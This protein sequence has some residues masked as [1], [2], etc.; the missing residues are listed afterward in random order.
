[1]GK[2]LLVLALTLFVIGIV[3]M[4]HAGEGHDAGYRWAAAHGINDT[5]YNSGNSQSFNEGV[6]NYAQDQG[7]Y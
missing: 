3:P 6:R 2:L 5:S 1:M 4:A 7:Y